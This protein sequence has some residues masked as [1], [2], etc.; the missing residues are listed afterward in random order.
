MYIRLAR[1]LALHA[2]SILVFWVLV[3]VASALVATTGFGNPLWNRLISDVPQA[4]PSESHTGQKLLESHYTK[5]YGVLAY[6]QGVDFRAEFKSAENTAQQLRDLKEQAENHGAQAK[7]LGDQAKAA[8]GEAQ[9][10]GLEA[11]QAGARGDIAKAGVLAEQA[12]SAARRAQDLAGQAQSAGGQALVLGNK[13]KA[14]SQPDWPVARSL[15]EA[16]APIEAELK[17]IPQVKSVAY[18]FV[19]YNAML[20]PQARELAAKNRQGFVV[21]VSLDLADGGQPGKY[22]SEKM[23]KVVRHTEGI[24]GKVQAAVAKH[25]PDN[26]KVAPLRV[27]I[28]DQDLVNKAGIQTLKED[29][30]RSE[31]IGIPISFLVMAIVF[32]GFLAALLPLGS[33]GVAISMSLAL[34]LGMTYIFEQQSFAVNVISVL[35]LGLSIDYGLLIVSRF[36]EELARLKSLPQ[37]EWSP[38][39]SAIKKPKTVARLQ[40]LDPRHLRALEIT[41]ATAGRTTFF[42]ALTV[43]IAASGMLFFRAE[44]L[45]SLGIAGFSVVLL[46]MIAAITLVSSL[47]FLFAAKLERPSILARIPGLRWVVR[48]AAVDTVALGDGTAMVSSDSLGASP[49][50]SRTSLE[51]SLDSGKPTRK[52][53]FD[54]VAHGVARRPWL[55]FILSAAVLVAACLPLSYLP[56]RN[57]LFDLLPI[58]NQQRLLYEDLAQEVPRVG[59]PPL[60]VVAKDTPPEKLDKW[61]ATHVADLKGV[62]HVFAANP[63]GDTKDSVAIVQL[64]TTDPGSRAAE[65]VVKAVRAQAHDFERFVVGQAANQIDFIDSLVEGLPWVLTVLVAITIF[66]LFMM[67]GSVVIPI[68]AL[69]INTL[70]LMAT[71]GI[72]TLVFVD[73]IGVG[74]LGAK[75]LPG[76]ESYVIVMLMCFGFG[77]SMDY[78]LFLLSRMKEVWDE[79][80]SAKRSVIEGLSRSGRIVTSAAT[81]LVFVFLCFVTG[82]MIV[83]KQVG[84]ILA[85][86]VAFDATIVRMVLVPSVMA[87]FG[88]ANWWAPGPLRRWHNKVSEKLGHLE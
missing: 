29:L 56:L 27:R 35:G 15:H 44:L 72:S 61:M 11:R 21:A 18:P 63:L 42:S 37:S 71:L 41:V 73:G 12:Q 47:M 2:R 17:T 68:Q 69:V 50:A 22:P 19:E 46:A 38:D 10:L 25:V 79:T 16:L 48:R 83:L 24:L 40:H 32:G 66:L 26:A 28:T 81:I 52:S 86:A 58:H 82:N 65:D 54:R 70:S 43:A 60:R 14:L 85:V 77:L 51:S 53:L 80:A 8:G 39:F 1:F 5:S 74:W 33:A 88:R 57:S 34:M 45:K 3:V 87:L 30:V 62:A 78:E 6:V 75:Q 9:R 59:L 7:T 64:E 13:A 23:L 67:S 4:T 55:S 36:R 49:V 84:F 20:D 31:S 76:L